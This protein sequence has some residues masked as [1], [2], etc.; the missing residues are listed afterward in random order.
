V[1]PETQAVWPTFGGQDTVS[2]PFE[3]DLEE[4]PHL[5]FVIN[6]QDGRHPFSYPFPG[7]LAD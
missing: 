1:L 6:Q 5:I 2:R 4:H 7:L 3:R